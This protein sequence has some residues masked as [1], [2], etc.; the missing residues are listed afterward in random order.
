MPLRRLISPRLWKHIALAAALFGI[1]VAM[2][3]AALESRALGEALGPEVEQLVSLDRA[4]LIRGYGGLLLIVAA[5]LALLIWYVRS[6]SRR[7]F[8]GRYRSWAWAAGAGFLFSASVSLELHRIWS[9]AISFALTLDTP[10]FETLCWLAPAMG[11]ATVLFRDL[12]ADMRDCKSSVTFLRLAFAGWTTSACALLGY[13]IPVPA[14]YAPLLVPASALLGHFCLFLAMLLHCRFVIYVSAE[15]PELRTPLWKAIVALATAPLR[16][17]YRALKNRRRVERKAEPDEPSP[18]P[19]APP[20]PS[21][22][23]PKPAA[24]E[25]ST[26]PAP[27]MRKKRKT[28]GANKAKPK[29]AKAQSSEE[30]P[31]AASDEDNRRLRADQP[32]ATMAMPKGLSK[33]ERRKLRKKQ[34]QQSQG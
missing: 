22:N 19:Q 26:K 29:P 1:G 16:A 23:N 17:M 4:R 31:A 30:Q 7:D 15:P 24:D 10:H 28:A 5:E 20:K 11:C 34:L 33:R 13:G 32:H 9:A 21:A 12:Y 8:S 18:K 6:R 14:A 2:L 27:K 25:A 3:W